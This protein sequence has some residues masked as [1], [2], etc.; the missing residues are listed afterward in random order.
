MVSQSIGIKESGNKSQAEGFLERRAMLLAAGIVLLAAAV[1]LGI[2]PIVTLDGDE[3]EV[4]TLIR[5]SPG[6]L[7]TG[8][9]VDLS[10]PPGH[11]LVLWIVRH[12][13]GE[14]V[15][16]YRAVQSVLA[17]LTVVMVMAICRLLV[18][19]AGIWLGVGLLMAVNPMLV[20]LSLLIRPY[21]VE[22]LL[23]SLA[24][25]AMLRWRRDRRLWSLVV[26]V[27]AIVA[28][29]NVHY[30][31]VFFWA[32][33]GLWWLWDSR[34]S[35]RQLTETVVA[36]LVALVLI[37]PT[38][39]FMMWQIHMSGLIL[40][41]AVWTYH[42]VG[43]P[44]YFICG[45]SLA[46]PEYCPLWLIITTVI[47]LAV[48]LIPSLLA[49]LWAVWKTVEAR[50]FVLAILFLPF[51]FMMAMSLHKPFFASRYIATIWPMF[52][53]TLVLGLS[54][55]RLRIRAAAF[56]FLVLLE[57]IGCVSYAARYADMYPP[58]LTPTLE[59]YGGQHFGLIAY[60]DPR[61]LIVQSSK[62]SLILR[63]N[64]RTLPKLVVSVYPDPPA[65]YVKDHLL[66][67]W[68]L[69]TLLASG[70]PEELW[71]Y[72]DSRPESQHDK[73][74]KVLEQTKQMLSG[75]YRLEKTWYWPNEQKAK[76]YLLKFRRPES[77]ASRESS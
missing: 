11:P 29:F 58:F 47:P 51:L 67:E 4:I 14:N 61:P 64:N 57:L 3:S 30:G 71:F 49:G 53:L 48:V 27:L 37:L 62:P 19:R 24:T 76:I 16:L 46:H 75:P 33:L 21:A 18:P 22:L 6:E 52:A 2:A 40:N 63:I 20:M 74:L 34:R 54:T 59:A 65:N 17:T 10:H 70:L 38:V 73:A 69:S 68:D 9:A 5:S 44:Y 50:G 60:P 56:V 23:L 32:A 1:R 26:Y 41:V 12:M 45:G 31:S 28:V 35:K 43:F 66:P 15:L 39:R 42:T 13:F 72:C 77:P 7:L 8:K 25:W 55:F 36:N